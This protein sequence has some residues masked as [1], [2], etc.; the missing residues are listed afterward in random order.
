MMQTIQ[1]AKYPAI[2]AAEEEMSIPLQVM[3]LAI[4]DAVL[5][6]MLN[7]VA[8]NT[9]QPIKI[10]LCEAFNQNKGTKVISILKKSYGDAAQILK[11]TLHSDFCVVNVLGYCVRT[12]SSFTYYRGKRDLL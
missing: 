10:S 2:S 9:W 5:L 3:A 1:S 6:H 7:T 8:P 4:F 11:S 12:L